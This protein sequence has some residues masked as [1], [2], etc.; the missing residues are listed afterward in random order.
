MPQASNK[1][2]W[3]CRRNKCLKLSNPQSHPRAKKPT[4]CLGKAPGNGR[5]VV[6]YRVMSHK[7]YVWNCPNC[8]FTCY[9][10][11]NLAAI[12]T[13]YTDTSFWGCLGSTARGLPQAPEL[14][15]ENVINIKTLSENV[16]SP[17]RW[18]GALPRACLGQAPGYQRNVAKCRNTYSLYIAQITT[19][20]FKRVSTA[21]LNITYIRSVQKKTCQYSLNSKLTKMSQS[22]II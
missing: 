8:K 5:N 7:I 13:I 14:M 15:S 2:V 20:L 17:R 19:Y 11:Q 18:P 3:N 10:S 6:W 9:L 21:T 12:W 22:T 4:A 1:C 16:K